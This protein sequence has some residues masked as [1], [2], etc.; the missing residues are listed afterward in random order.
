M[1]ALD[2]DSNVCHSTGGGLVADHQGDH[3]D[4]AGTVKCR[5]S[6]IGERWMHLVGI[7]VGM[8]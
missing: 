3:L 7:D 8:P 1:L 6:I 5:I 2:D 4:V